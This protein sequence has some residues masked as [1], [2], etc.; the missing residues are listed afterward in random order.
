MTQRRETTDSTNPRYSEDDGIF[1][2]CEICGNDEE[3]EFE[4][5]IFPN[6]EDQLIPLMR[7][8]KCG[9][10]NESPYTSPEYMI[11][12][13]FRVNVVMH[14]EN[15]HVGSC[16][17]SCSSEEKQPDSATSGDA[18][19]DILVGLQRER[20]QKKPWRIWPIL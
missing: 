8:Q 1:T 18:L 6:Q 20:L 9:A 16:K 10:S 11:G 17:P 13:A 7:C 12:P 15:E 14:Q 3:S 19:Q 4:E 5:I 2:P